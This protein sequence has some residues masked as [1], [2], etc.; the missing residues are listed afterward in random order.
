M[1]WRT[2]ARPVH[3]HVTTR[4]GPVGWHLPCDPN[5]P[6]RFPFNTGFETGLEP[7]WIREVDVDEIGMAASSDTRAMDAWTWN[8]GSMAG[9]VEDGWIRP[10]KPLVAVVGREDLSQAIQGELQEGEGRRASMETLCTPH[11]GLLPKVVSPRKERFGTDSNSRSYGSLIKKGWIEKQAKKRPAV[12]VCLLEKKYVA[13]DPNSWNDTC[14]TVDYIYRVVQPHGTKL[15]LALVE[16]PEEYV[17]LAEEQIYALRKR[18]YI[19]SGAVV[20]LQMSDLKVSL[21]KLAKVVYEAAWGYYLNKV[22]QVKS[23]LQNTGPGGYE[24]LHVRYWF[25]MGVY[26]EFVQDWEAALKA[27]RT[28]YELMVSLVAPVPGRE[29]QFFQWS[30]ERDVVAEHL[31]LKI[32]SLLLQSRTTE[33]AIRHFRRHI[34]AFRVCPANMPHA[35]L[36]WHEG[37]LSR[38]YHLFGKLLLPEAGIASGID[39]PVSHHPGWYIFSAVQHMA[40]RRATSI[41]LLNDS[42]EGFSREDQDLLLHDGFFLGQQMRQDGTAPTEKE[43]LLF[44]AK[45]ESSIDHDPMIIGALSTALDLLK[46][47]NIPRVKH[48]AVFLLAKEH[49]R[50]GDHATAVELLVSILKEY[51]IWH[52]DAAS[53]EAM[54]LLRECYQRLGHNVQHAL[55][56]LELCTFQDTLGT[57]LC[58]AIFD[59]TIAILRDYSPQDSVEWNIEAQS[60]LSTSLCCLAGFDAPSAGAAP[61]E[62]RPQVLRVSIFSYFPQDLDIRGIKV[63]MADQAYSR[64]SCK[65][66]QPTLLKSLSWTTWT[67]M[68]VRDTPGTLECARVQVEVANRVFFIWNVPGSLEWNS[69]MLTQ[70]WVPMEGAFTSLKQRLDIFPSKEKCSLKIESEANAYCGDFFPLEIE[71]NTFDEALQEAR[72]EFNCGGSSAS[73]IAFYSSESDGTVVELNDG[74]VRIGYLP[75]MQATR[76]KVFC[77]TNAP[78]DFL[79]HVQISFLDGKSRSQVQATQEVTFLRPFELSS[80]IISKHGHYLLLKEKKKSL[81]VGVECILVTSLRVPDCGADLYIQSVMLEGPQDGAVVVVQQHQLADLKKGGTILKKGETISC[82]FCIRAEAPGEGVQIGAVKILWSRVGTPSSHVETVLQLPH[83]SA[84]EAMLHVNFSC[85]ESTAVRESFLARCTIQNC[86]GISQELSFA[87]GD[88]AS[89][90]LTG[91]KQDHLYVLPGAELAVSLQFLALAC[92]WQT[93]PPIRFEALDGQAKLSIQEDVYILPAP[94]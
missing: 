66:D 25:K 45:K 52:W 73:A 23:K 62:G 21:K 41:D 64:I 90:A 40:K 12:V 43:W 2:H 55:C 4:D 47:T 92:G 20:N 27:I 56:S 29:T 30:A 69:A 31:S 78:E 11:C 71:I 8:E 36:A 42:S 79:I 74:G 84:S 1:P 5:S 57:A 18:I 65:E 61:L 63:G 89:F 91:V 58:T 88:S 22:N 48:V 68:A 87:V 17:V 39:I 16:D 44:T 26:A 15:V 3:N 86:T 10:P 93:L 76:Y 46:N 51:R 70:G 54:Q 19:D 13:G 9:A 33:D 67:F 32:C 24:A 72:L 59:S 35:F 38:Q 28:A 81:P 82:P 50:A 49:I 6:D 77:K 34:Q 75:P 83:E 53:I 7:G 60:E 37:W 94:L 14:R 80:R 85:P